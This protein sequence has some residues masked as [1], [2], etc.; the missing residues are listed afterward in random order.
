[1]SQFVS[2]VAPHHNRRFFSFHRPKRCRG[3]GGVLE[4]GFASECHVSRARDAHRV[5]TRFSH[6]CS[7]C[8]G[9]SEFAQ[10]EAP[11]VQ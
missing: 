10:D 3:C 11:E 9:F 4:R 8:L 5:R 1:V 7:Q 2:L 6:A